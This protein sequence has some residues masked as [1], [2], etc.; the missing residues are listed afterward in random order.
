[1]ETD[2]QNKN[3]NESFKHMC[4]WIFVILRDVILNE[5]EENDINFLLEFVFK[6]FFSC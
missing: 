2:L 1:M 4:R 3:A 5:P 6:Y